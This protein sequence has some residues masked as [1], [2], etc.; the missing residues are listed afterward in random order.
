MIFSI[1][2]ELLP[3]L[4]GQPTVLYTYTFQLAAHLGTD[5]VC[6]GLGRG[7]IRTEDCSITYSQ[8]RSHWA[9]LLLRLCKHFWRE[10]KTG[11]RRE[12]PPAPSP[13][14]QTVRLSMNQ[15]QEK[16]DAVSSSIQGNVGKLS[17]AH[18]SPP[19]KGV[20]FLPQ[21]LSTRQPHIVRE[22]CDILDGKTICRLH[23]KTASP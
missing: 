17:L 12:I 19:G 14:L 8:L 1:F 13:P 20:P 2:R 9:T 22:Y 3:P 6:R 5:R 7:Q 23:R 4:R 21:N 10:P 16:R 18:I 11:S 15:V